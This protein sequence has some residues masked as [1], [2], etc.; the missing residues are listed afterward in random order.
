MIMRNYEIDSGWESY[1]ISKFLLGIILI[2]IVFRRLKVE[3]IKFNEEYFWATLNQD[4]RSKNT[5]IW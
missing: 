5:K 2:Y 1:H 3:R 4:V